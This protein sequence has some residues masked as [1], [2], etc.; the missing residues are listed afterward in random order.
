MT[1][2]V[3][4]Q[5]DLLPVRKTQNFVGTMDGGHKRPHAPDFAERNGRQKRRNQGG[6]Y[7]GIRDLPMAAGGGGGV[8]IPEDAVY[9]ILC[10][11]QKIGSVIGKGGSIIKTLRQDSGAKIK[12]ADAIPGVEERVIIISGPERA[13]G[14]KG[15]RG[16]GGKAGRDGHRGRE[17]RDR[18][19][20]KEGKEETENNNNKVS[21]P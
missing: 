12:I 20:D 1:P 17:G 21:G 10:P 11:A 7:N 5:R 9:R 4:F 19:R 13:G 6:G 8:P 18:E 2:T 14:E 15:N 16:G 3:H